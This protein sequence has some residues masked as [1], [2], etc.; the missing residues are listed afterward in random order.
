MALGSWHRTRG[1]GVAADS[2]ATFPRIRR[3]TT[4]A[5]HVLLAPLLLFVLSVSWLG[6]LFLFSHPYVWHSEML[7]LLLLLLAGNQRNAT[8]HGCF[9]AKETV[10]YQKEE[11]AV[12]SCDSSES[13]QYSESG[14]S[15][16]YCSSFL[17]R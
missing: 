8:C 5:S 15:F 13:C 11:G 1:P 14:E 10:S 7:L 3:I 12:E 4:L 9:F 17:R 6:I 16:V 2:G